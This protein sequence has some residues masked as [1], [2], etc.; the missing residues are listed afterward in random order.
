MSETSREEKKRGKRTLKKNERVK[1]TSEDHSVRRK[2]TCNV[3]GL[4]C[5]CVC[6]CGKELTFKNIRKRRM[7]LCAMSSLP[8][9]NL[10][11]SFIRFFAAAA[12]PSSSV[13]HCLPCRANHLVPFL[14]LHLFL[15]FFFF[16]SVHIRSIHSNMYSMV[17]KIDT[18]STCPCALVCVLRFVYSVVQCNPY[19][20]DE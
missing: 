18:P 14:A 3:N 7:S 1:E 5:V 16:V 19:D 8:H 4:C 11:F 13:F 12:A 17:H 10:A 2:Y 15:F 6:L 9:F 20:D